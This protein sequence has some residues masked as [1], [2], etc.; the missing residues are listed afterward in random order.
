MAQ[1]HVQCD[2]TESCKAMPDI[3]HDACPY[4]QR[5]RRVRLTYAPRAGAMYKEGKFNQEIENALKKEFPEADIQELWEGMAYGKKQVE[6]LRAEAKQAH[7]A[8]QAKAKQARSTGSDTDQKQTRQNDQQQAGHDQG[9]KAEPEPEPMTESERLTK[10]NDI[11]N[12]MKQHVKQDKL[13][14]YDKSFKE[15]LKTYP[16][17]GL[18]LSELF[19]SAYDTVVLELKAQTKSEHDTGQAKDRTDQREAFKALVAEALKLL[20]LPNTGKKKAIGLLAKDHADMPI[21]DIIKAVN[22]AQYEYEC[23]L[24]DKDP[25]PIGQEGKDQD[26]ELY[27]KGLMDTGTYIVDGVVYRPEA[28]MYKPIPDTK[29]TDPLRLVFQ[30]KYPK[31]HV[32]WPIST[33]S[34]VVQKYRDILSN[35]CMRQNIIMNPYKERYVNVKNGM[36]DM[37]TGKIKPHS[38]HYRSTH[39]LQFNYVAPDKRRPTPIDDT[40]LN[41]LCRTEFNDTDSKKVYLMKQMRSL[42][43]FP[44]ADEHVM[45]FVIGKKRI[46]KSIQGRLLK[47]AAG[48]DNYSSILLEFF[49]KEGAN[50][51]VIARIF[52]KLFNISGETPKKRMPDMSQLKAGTG[53]DG[54][55]I[56]FKFGQTF[57]YEEYV[58]LINFMNN[59]PNWD[60]REGMDARIIPIRLFAD[61]IPYADRDPKFIEKYATEI[62]D[63]M[64]EALD[65]ARIVA[66]HAPDQNGICRAGIRHK[67]NE[68]DTITI[69]E[70]EIDYLHQAVYNTLEM[71]PRP[72]KFDE[73]M[74]MADIIAV[75][76]TELRRTDLSDKDIIAMAN[77][78]AIGRITMVQDARHRQNG[79]NRYS[80]LVKPGKEVDLSQYR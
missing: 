79:V 21:D 68:N 18:Y 24:N 7:E 57:T 9:P 47:R 53:G 75:V 51:H 13:D 59:A 52:N 56:D 12:K 80:L 30:A 27:L 14:V 41:R 71:N 61:T 16:D 40:E 33:I 60:Y 62:D 77:E 74:S 31:Q 25:G 39:Q 64:S 1:E 8:A 65:I 55:T 23:K 35:H 48:K 29:R 69:L 38:L 6:Q 10:T 50:L 73:R 3:H 78:Q 45:W 2:R 66:G 42:A 5:M 44:Y 20:V 49:A 36:F 70:A 46:G 26:I 17:I 4:G 28:G 15:K 19:D 37:H 11:I 22:R 76:M 63:I 72:P 43:L 32:A 67:P 34:E 54:W 58:T